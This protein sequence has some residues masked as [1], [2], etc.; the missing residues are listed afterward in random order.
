M[1]KAMAIEEPS[2]RV[3][4]SDPPF[5]YRFYPSYVV[6]ETELA[7]DFDAASQTGFRRIADYIFGNNQAQS[8]GSRKIAMTAPVTI[9]PKQQGWRMHFVMPGSETLASLPKP[10]SPDVKLRTVSEHY[11]ASIRFS[12]FTTESAIQEQ[13]DKLLA[14]MSSKRLVANGPVQVARYNGPF[15]L[16]WLR[17]NEILI[18][19]APG[20]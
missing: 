12:G 11:V 6:A 13:T 17:R 16:P 18:P 2:F 7:G 9:E 15:T 10:N 3:I 20:R 5:E 19:V 4:E 1:G 8:G 14:W